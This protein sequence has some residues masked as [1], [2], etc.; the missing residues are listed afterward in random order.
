MSPKAWLRLNQAL[1]VPTIGMTV[2]CITP[3]PGQ[4]LGRD[5]VYLTAISHLALVL[6]IMAAIAGARAER[7]QD[8]D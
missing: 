8:E 6:A 5:L 7:A 4:S 2:F 3:G 1:L